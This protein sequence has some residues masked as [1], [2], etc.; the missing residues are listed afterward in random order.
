MID[1]GFKRDVKMY[2]FFINFGVWFLVGK[3]L[4]S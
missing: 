1:D 2:L 4:F 3:V